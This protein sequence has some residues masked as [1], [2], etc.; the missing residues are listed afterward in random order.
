MPFVFLGQ[1]EA[2]NLLDAA[3]QGQ[4]ARLELIEKI[5]ESD[6]SVFDI[7]DL[8]HFQ[9]ELA[10]TCR[11]IDEIEKRLTFSLVD[12]PSVPKFGV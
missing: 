11:V 9:A 8:R 1:D 5:E 12:A 2:E 6:E 10:R 7:T 4:V 3:R